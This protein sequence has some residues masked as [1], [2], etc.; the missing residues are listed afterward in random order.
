[1]GIIKILGTAATTLGTVVFTQ[2]IA[3][4]G[5][6]VPK[7]RPQILNYLGF[8]TIGVQW[9]SFIHAGGLF[10]NK[11]TEKYYDLIGSLTHLSTIGIS[12]LALRPLSKISVRQ[13]IVSSCAAIWAIRLGSFL[14]Y[15]IHNS[16]GVDSRFTEMKEDWTKFFTA[17]TIQGA[18]VFITLLSVL[19]I[20][21][22]IDKIP[23]K[24]INYVGMGV[25]ATGF[26]MEVVA[27]FQ[28]LFFKQNPENAGKWIDTGL[29]SI[30]R[31]PNYF[32]EITLWTGVSLM[33]IDQLKNKRRLLALCISPVFVA[34]LLI[35]VSGIP[36]LEQKADDRWGDNELYQKYKNNTPVLV[37]FIKNIW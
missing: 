13:A 15:R 19:V 20:N 32:G 31:H 34:C 1:M 27:D 21:Q 9:V 12:V 8:Y 24:P 18:W 16:G 26:A 36:L 2:G 5:T 28:K 4:L 33:C 11:P 35:F 10:G 37:P 14:F 17:W 29:W 6:Q 30:S 23:L 3:V 7:L 25:W 22:R